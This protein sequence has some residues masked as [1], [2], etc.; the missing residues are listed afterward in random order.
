MESG[1]AASLLRDFRGR[2]W[3]SVFLRGGHL[4]SVVNLGAVVLGVPTSTLPSHSGLAVLL[5]GVLVWALDL[6]HKPGHLVEG[7]GLSMLL[8]LVL[9]VWMVLAPGLSV[10]L[11]WA[12]VLW[13]AVFSHAP[14]SFRNARLR[15]NR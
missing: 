15:P 2:R 8:K 13:S 3:L 9:V 10:P 4:V 11:F 7:A 5:T 6:W 12:I 14:A 1:R